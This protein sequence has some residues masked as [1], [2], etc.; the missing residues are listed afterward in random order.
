MSKPLVLVFAPHYLPGYKAGGPI[1][2]IGNMV[3]ALGD[4]FEFRI[5]T[6]DRDLGDVQPYPEI[7]RNC[8]TAVGKS[9]VWYGA[10]QWPDLRPFQSAPIYL[11]SFFHPVYSLKPLLLRRMR[12]LRG[13][14]LLAPRGEFSEGGLKISGP[15]KHSFIKLTS[16]VG[17]HRGVT[18]HASSGHEAADI[19]RMLGSVEI[20]IALDL[21]GTSV[22][23]W[24]PPSNDVLSLAF[25]S[26]ISP[27]KN[28]L[29]ALEIMAEVKLPA[30][31]TVYGPAEDVAYWRLCQATA[32]RLPPHVE[33]VYAG[34]LTPAQVEPELARHDLFLFPTWG[35]NYGHVIRE[36]LSAGLPVLTS[37][38]TPWQDLGDAGSALPLS[39]PRAFA[40]WIDKFGVLSPDQREKRR[41][42]ARRRGDNPVER[43]Q[44]VEATRVLLRR[45]TAL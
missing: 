22:G 6:S 18:F 40:R 35:E 2:S 39:D 42:A 1:P 19:R 36:A 8:W 13:N 37:D 24:S 26:R 3:E 21:S 45:L 5:I 30:R 12:R 44:S 41:D 11:N 15:K 43:E 27:K 9:Q 28:L 31:L 17:L 38:Q 32:A 34:T 20:G 25:L 14:V 16:M 29:G 23:A 33:F 10:N 4:E 7:P